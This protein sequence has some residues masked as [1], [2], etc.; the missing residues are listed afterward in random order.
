MDGL[1]GQLDGWTDGQTGGQTDGLVDRQMDGW[2]D[3]RD[4]TDCMDGTDGQMGWMDGWIDGPTHTVRAFL[5]EAEQGAS[6][7]LRGNPEDH[8]SDAPQ[9]GQ[10]FGTPGATKEVRQQGVSQPEK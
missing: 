2:T 10:I 7:T 5:Q 4:R 1:H 3:W 6:S 8:Q 9:S